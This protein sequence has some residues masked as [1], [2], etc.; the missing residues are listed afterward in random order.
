MA[1]IGF[2]LKKM[3]SK[4]G[5]LSML[6]AYGYAGI[7]CTGPMILGLLLLLG[8]AVIAKGAG[9]GEQEIE[10][11]NS[12]ITY[13]L[14]I[15]MMLTNTF[16]L[17]TTRYTADQLY[18]KQN[19][20]ILPSFWGSVGIML[21][22]GCILYGCFLF[23]A[24]IPLLY[25]FLVLV[26]FG[27]LL[28]VWTQM[29]YLTAIKDYRGILSAFGAALVCA[30]L[31]A[32]L[33]LETGAAIIPAMLFS[34]AAA[35]G[36]M[37]VWYYVLLLRYFPEGRESAFHFLEWFDTYPQLSFLGLFLSL[38]LFG[39]ILIMWTSP[40][41]VQIQ[42]LFYAAPMYD[43][44]ALLA[45]LSILATTIHFV[46]SVEVNFY[47]KYRNYFSLFNDGG[48]LMDIRQAE[49]EMKATLA[50]ELV[51][52]Y[53]KQFFV[54]IVFILAG[55]FMLPYLPLGVDAD[56]LGIYRV[57]CVGYAFYAIGNCAM[58]I[59]LYFADNKGALIS[60]TVFMAVSCGG[61][62]FLK[63]ASTKLYGVGFLI[64]SIGFAI[65]ALFLL[66]WYL[67]K[68]MY[69]VL[70]SQPIVAE[71]KRGWLSA[72]SEKMAVR[73]REKYPAYFSEETEDE[74]P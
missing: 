60:G 57:L 70:C 66:W 49:R 22:P 6:K 26:F 67:K 64:G 63:N 36:I 59:Q 18:K 73:Y 68:L 15:S 62:V 28:I 54:T 7:V 45:F 16:S 31:L 35:Y 21:I 71:K 39:H 51:Y 56:M 47:P 17:V 42:G 20:K 53:M 46:T 23:F 38:G 43:V 55:T 14:V 10:L 37:A 30:W 13:T 32:L 40:V 61:T 33:I 5:L 34:V 65:T 72:F 12:M 1:G 19:S 25:Q 41:R 52:T 9:A 4:K 69:H 48:S 50:Q 2:E 3:F 44:P 74:E 11:L 58:L 29:N 27:E 24:G 8:V